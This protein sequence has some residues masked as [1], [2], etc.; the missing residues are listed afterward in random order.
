MTPFYTMNEGDEIRGNAVLQ[1]IDYT[2]GQ[3]IQQI[4]KWATGIKYNCQRIVAQ[5]NKYI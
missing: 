1:L 3:I 4:N 5:Q 2:P